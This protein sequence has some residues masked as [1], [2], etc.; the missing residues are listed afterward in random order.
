[1]LTR[2]DDFPVHQTPE[3]L[4]HRAASD[5]NAYDRYWFNGVDA[6]GSFYFGAAL[7]LYPHLH[8]MDAHFSF[9]GPDGVQHSLHASR[10]A[11]KE[12]TQTQVGPISLAV[13]EPMRRLRFASAENEHGIACDLTFVSRAPALEEP[14]TR[15][16]AFDSTRNLVDMT[17]FT[18]FGSWEGWVRAGGV[19]TRIDPRTTHATRDRSWGVRSVGANAPSRPA[20]PPAFGWLWAPVHFADECVL[21]GFFQR[22][23]GSRWGAG[24][25]RVAA[26]ATP[27]LT[28]DDGDPSVAHFEPGEHAQSFVRGTRWVERGVFR[29]QE[30]DGAERALELEALRRFNMNGLGYAHPKWGH[31]VWQGEQRVESEV[32]K[33]SDLAPGN[34][35]HNHIH[36]LV[37]ARLGE[38]RGVGLLEQ[39]LFGPLSRYGF[40]DLLGGAS[41]R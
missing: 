34:P 6:G 37:S 11:P 24:G 41:A 19:T 3:P 29:W 14:R 38:K 17:R 7:G 20:A 9:L 15:M 4:A 8:V 21:L 33:E 32:W 39:I 23:D 22:A 35:F 13:L 18:Q 16:K 25:A 1:M 26:S 30:R 12:P 10:L 40:T 2:F 27:A 28:A 36:A 5:P 31:G